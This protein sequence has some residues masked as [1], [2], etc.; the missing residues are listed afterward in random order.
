MAE[1]LI[2]RTAESRR[3]QRLRDLPRAVGLGAVRFTEADLVAFGVADH[4]GLDDIGREIREGSDNASRLDGAGDH[5][6]WIH[7]FETQT[8]QLSAVA[9]EI[10]PG[11]PVLRADDRG[12]GSKERTKRR[13]E[14]RQ[15]MCL[16]AEENDVRVTNRREVT[17]H[18]RPHV[19]VAVR[20]EH[21]QA[22][23]LHRAQMRA[24]RKQHDVRAGFGQLRTDVAADG[25][26]ARDDDSHESGAGLQA[27]EYAFATAP[28]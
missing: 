4:T 20:A 28:R 10:P 8:I 24:A 5:A 11:D 9:L 14:R 23:L 22:A 17:G 12:V 16:D 21:A 2:D 25:A 19:E 13:R 27:C 7:A 26:G 18:L 1:S 15:T 6:A 3:N